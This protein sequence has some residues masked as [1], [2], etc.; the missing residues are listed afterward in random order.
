MKLKG[1]V[2]KVQHSNTYALT[3]EGQR[4]AIFYTKV[5]NRVRRPLMAADQIPAPLPV[6]HSLRT[7][8]RSS[9]SP[10]RWAASTTGS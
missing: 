3:P 2:R 1:L 9:Y 10:A 7:P 4:F 5:G 6:R 8:L